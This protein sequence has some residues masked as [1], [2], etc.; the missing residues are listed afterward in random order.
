MRGCQDE[1]GFLDLRVL[2]AVYS[3]GD[4]DPKPSAPKLSSC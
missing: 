4:S 2:S 1:G 3:R